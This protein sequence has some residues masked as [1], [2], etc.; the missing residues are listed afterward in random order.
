MAKLASDGDAGLGMNSEAALPKAELHCHIEG[1]I[2]PRLVRRLAERNGIAL[3]DTLFTGDGRFAWK[4]FADFLRVYDAISA[5]LRTPIDYRDI[6]YDY[7][8]T[9]AREGAIYVEFFASPDHAA[10][11]GIRYGE[12]LAGL[13]AAIDAAARD[14]R[15]VGRIVIISVRHLGPDCA[16]DLVRTMRAEPHPYVV[17]FGMGGDERRFHPADFAAAFHL[18][19]DAGYGCT[20]HAGE[21]MGPESVRAAIDHLPITRIGHGVRAAEDRALLEEI[22]ERGLVLEVCP[23]SNLALG[24][25]ADAAAHPLRRLIAAGCRVTLNSD[26]PPYFDTSIGQEYA[27]AA[28][29]FQLSRGQLVGITRTALQGSFADSA[30]LATLSAR[31]ENFGSP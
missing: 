30:T 27:G 25:Y 15:I 18:A 29:R 1:T 7:L 20:A 3:P 8:A 28:D 14:Y 11:G 21:M 16:L 13:V 17:G 10:A 4:S 2:P 31:L 9:C 23:G 26:D 5:C 19:A 22:A 24:L 6:C 12:M